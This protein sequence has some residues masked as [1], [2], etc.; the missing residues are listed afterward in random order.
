MLLHD[1]NLIVKLFSSF[2]VNSKYTTTMGAHIILFVL[3]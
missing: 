1:F 3:S 2:E